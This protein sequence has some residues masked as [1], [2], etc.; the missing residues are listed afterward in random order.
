PPERL[1]PLLEAPPLVRLP[2]LLGSPPSPQES[3]EQSL[4]A[5]AEGASAAV[6]D[7][8]KSVKRPKRR[9]RGREEREKGVQAVMGRFFLI[10]GF[11]SRERADG[12][13][14]FDRPISSEARRRCA[15]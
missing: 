3:S 11:A 14:T 7:P 1:P 12:R 5:Q 13:R 15:P 8:N 6:T 9:V 2:P 10:F 4:G